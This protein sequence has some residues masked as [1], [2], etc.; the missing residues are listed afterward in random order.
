MNSRTKLSTRLLLIYTLIL[1]PVLGLMAVVVD[2][3]ARDTLLGDIEENL[4]VAAELAFTSLPADPGGFQAWADEIFEIGAF[5]TTLIDE[6]GVVLADSHTDPATMDNHGQREEILEAEAGQVGIAQ[7]VSESTGFDQLYVALPPRDGLF[8]RTSVPT[9]VINDD[10]NSLRWAIVIS[11]LAVGV[12]GVLVVGL[13]ARRMARPIEELTD[14]AMAAANGEPSVAPRRSKIAE[15]DQLGLA[16]AT[17]AS[18]LGSRV[19]DAE[20]ASETLDVVLSALPQGTVL[21]EADESVVYANPSAEALLGVVPEE[22]SALAPFQF[23]SAV[24][25]ARDADESVRAE[26]EHGLPVKKLQAV[27]TPFA[28]DGRVLL[29]II[30]VTQRERADSVRRDFVA[31]ASHELKTPVA[32]IVASAEAMQIA[33]SRGDESAVGFAQRVE[34]SARQ[35]DRLVSDL[36][37]LSR[38]EREEPDLATTRVDLMVRDEVERVRKRS[39]D[40]GVSLSVSTQPATAEVSNR[41]LSIAVRNLL[42]NA[43]RYTDEGGSIDVSVT[44]SDDLAITVADTGIGIPTRDL[45]RVFE[46]FYRVDSA[47]ARATGGTG[48]GLSIVKHVAVSHGGTVSVSSELG[49]GTSVTMSLPIR[50]DAGDN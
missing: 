23:Q 24:R 32:T 26:A 35:L 3:V 17:M 36:L 40:K 14:Q 1:L 31:N 47:R 39:N 37:D 33:M 50:E 44:E 12:L 41:D 30:D 34:D 15:L 11:G 43:I 8:I 28:E 25:E 5:R 10:L 19:V 9:R 29:L 4:A 45:E 22:L 38:L 18:S 6:D 48:L 2:R 16:I 7:R 13:F 27:A 20:Q 42:D 49:V 21:V 46:R